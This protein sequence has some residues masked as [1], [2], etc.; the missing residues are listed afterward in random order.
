MDRDQP[1]RLRRDMFAKPIER[2]EF[3]LRRMGLDVG[4]SS[5]SNQLLES[6]EMD[7]RKIFVDQDDPVDVLRGWT[8]Q[9]RQAEELRELEAVMEVVF[10]QRIGR[11]VGIPAFAAEEVAAAEPGQNHNARWLGLHEGRFPRCRFEPC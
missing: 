4:T 2:T 7:G 10:A 6:F 1:F 3:L 9:S 11:S 5:P 8:E